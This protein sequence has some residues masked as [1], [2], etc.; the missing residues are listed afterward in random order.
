MAKLILLRHLLNDTTS[1]YS[2]EENNL[3]N[4]VNSD[5]TFPKIPLYIN[6]DYQF[7]CNGNLENLTYGL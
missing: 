1:T 4:L 7:F 3:R 5:I 2:P 6:D